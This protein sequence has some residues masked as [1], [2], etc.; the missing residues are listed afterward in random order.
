MHRY[1]YKGTGLEVCLNMRRICQLLSKS[2]I[3]AIYIIDSH[4]THTASQTLHKVDIVISIFTDVDIFS[5]YRPS[6]SQR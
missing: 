2:Y 5:N 1:L 3:V 6:I 4:L